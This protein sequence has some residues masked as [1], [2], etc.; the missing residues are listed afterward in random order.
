MARHLIP[1]VL[2]VLLVGCAAGGAPRQYSF[3]AAA[4]EPRPWPQ[5]PGALTALQARFAQAAAQPAGSRDD[6]AAVIAVTLRDLAHPQ[7]IVEEVRWLA[8]DLA[9]AQAAW[10]SLTALGGQRFLYVL[11]KR[12]GQWQVFRRYLVAALPP[13][14]S[15]GR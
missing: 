1:V 5:G 12:Q 13:P 15:Q 8:P 10:Q 9:M 11:A 3:P 14:G 2:S 4:E 7:G 6:Q